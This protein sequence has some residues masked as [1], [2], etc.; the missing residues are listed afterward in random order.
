MFDKLIASET[1]K[2]IKFVEQ[3]KPENLSIPKSVQKAK[4]I[5]RK[6]DVSS[7]DTERVFSRRTICSEKSSN[8]F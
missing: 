2:S 5:A 3:Q 8:C 7:A 1:F 6:I 4:N